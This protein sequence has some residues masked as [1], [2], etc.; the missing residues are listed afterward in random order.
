MMAL[1]TGAAGFIGSRL[2]E[3]LLA[4]GDEV[5][6]IDALTDYYARGDKEQNVS[7]LRE[8]GDFTFVEGDLND[9]ALTGLLDGVAV[10]YHLAG[11]PGV[12]ASWG[13]DFDGY[14]RQNVLA[15]QRLLEA[16]RQHSLRKLI[17]A[18]SSSVYGEAD[19]Y[20][21]SESM[22]PHPISPYGVTKLAAEHLCHTYRV[23]FSV[24]TASLRLFSVYGP[25]Q[26]PDMAFSR[27][28]ACAVRGG[29]FELNGDGEQT[30]D[31]T[32]VEDVVSAMRSA[33]VADFVGVANV[34]GGA[35]ISM[36][37]VIEV[38]T[39]LCGPV[40]VVRRPHTAGD[41][42][43][44]SADTRVAERAF[45]YMPKTGLRDGMRAMVEWERARAVITA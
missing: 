18:S 41:V 26:R 36:N 23:A 7:R 11:Q 19:S 6:A 34:G 43:H 25:R 40:R 4:S 21:L 35:R 38:L 29:T 15:T 27:L 42:R 12:R 20:P 31:W 33:A 16:C 14:V 28:V 17:Y 1:V 5:V 22:V 37:E 13:A 2:C 39:D 8:V 44:T 10:I 3:H 32:F 30:R 24:P 45:G 9:I